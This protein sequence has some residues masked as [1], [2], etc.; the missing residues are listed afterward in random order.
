MIKIYLVSCLVVAAACVALSL[1]GIVETAAQGIIGAVLVTFGLV[2][3]YV[4]GR[5]DFDKE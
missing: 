2:V 4:D 3:G 1:T 5:K